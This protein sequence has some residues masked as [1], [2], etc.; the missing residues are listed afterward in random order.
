MFDPV[1]DWNNPEIINEITELRENGATWEAIADH[2][3]VNKATLTQAYKR[4]TGGFKIEDKGVKKQDLTNILALTR[5]GLT[6]GEIAK[7]VGTTEQVIKNTV[8][9]AKLN[10]QSSHNKSFIQRKRDEKM[11]REKTMER[12]EELS[13][14]YSNSSELM[15]RSAFKDGN[16]GRA[17]AVNMHLA[18]CIAIG[19][20]VDLDDINS[21]YAAFESYI[22]MCTQTDSPVTLLT[23]CLALGINKKTLSEWQKGKHRENTQA[24]KDFADSVLFAI[25]AGIETC[26]ATGLINPVVGI[27]WEKAH[28]K[29]I[30]ADKQTAVAD[31]PDDRRKSAQEIIDEYEGVELP[32]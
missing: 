17:A 4:K 3:G 21:L 7:R 28:F 19:A 12:I 16:E 10:S 15:A 8:Y 13:A 31:E 24:Y 9:R 29:E 20:M 23:A 5:Q 32:E 25:Q 30:E 26:M 6:Y 11:K 22:K 1:L 18:Q 2:F 14:Q 27:W